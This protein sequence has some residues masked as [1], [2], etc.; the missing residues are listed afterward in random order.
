MSSFALSFLL[1]SN[2]LGCDSR[3][4]VVGPSLTSLFSCKNHKLDASHLYLLLGHATEG[5]S[6][7]I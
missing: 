4:G 1:S 3:S 7:L 5:T 6:E 2:R